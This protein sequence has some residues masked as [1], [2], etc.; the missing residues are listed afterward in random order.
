MTMD[1]ERIASMA[2]NEI[3]FSDSYK[4]HQVGH[5]DL[6]LGGDLKM[7]WRGAVSSCMPV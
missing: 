5:S 2:E 6:T 3:H 1:A 7:V 4:S